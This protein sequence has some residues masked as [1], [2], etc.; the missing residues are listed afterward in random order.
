MKEFKKNILISLIVAFVSQIYI[1]IFNDDFRVSA[2]IIFLSIIFIFFKN[3]DIIITSIVTANV[4]FLL[5]VIILWFGG[6]SFYYS[7]GINYPVIFFYLS[8]GMVFSL[9]NIRNQKNIYLLFTSLCISELVGNLVETVF[10]YNEDFDIDNIK[11]LIMVCLVRSSITLI[12]VNI[13]KEYNILIEKEE[14]DER[15]RKLLFLI[16]SLKTEIYFMNKNMN[17]IEGIM[18]NSFEL[19]EKLDVSEIDD[20]I[21]SISLSITKDIHEIKKDYIRVIK[22]I[23]E[24]THIK[25]KHKEMSLVYIFNILEDSTIK[26]IDS[27]GSSIK[28]NFKTARDIKVKDHYILISILRNLINNSIESIDSKKGVVDVDYFCEG[29]KFIFS[30]SDNGNGI[31]DSDKD[32]IFNP[33]FSTKFNMDT[34]DI[35][36]GIGLT[37]VKEMVEV[38]FSG[39]ISVES[40]YGVGT[41][42]EIIIPKEKLEG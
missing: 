38:H 40:E 11:I 42:F 41:T 28:V 7:F 30:V 15:Y 24:V 16:S 22:G 25:A 31:K 26:Y 19:Y 33:G 18:S 29:E 8:F 13:I 3:V 36:R 5:R 34:G 23:E 27:I 6:S 37:I 17:N 9:L 1:N 21:K 32:Y 14:H 35:N 10:R 4:V 20:D 12:F 2:G 39:C